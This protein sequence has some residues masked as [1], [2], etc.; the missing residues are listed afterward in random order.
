[1]KKAIFLMVLA[2]FSVSSFAQDMKNRYLFIKGTAE[3][4]GHYEFFIVN[5]TREAKSNGYVVTETES[6]AAHT[7]N[8]VVT[9]NTGAPSDEN[10]Y[11]VKISLLSNTDSLEIISFDF[12][13]TDLN[14]VYKYTRNLFLDATLYIPLFNESEFILAEQLRNQWK[15]KWIY[16]RAS[17][18][19]PITFYELQ[20]TGLI[21][22]SALHN[23][24]DPNI[25]DPQDHKIMA[26][27]GFTVGFE[28]QLFNCFS[29]ELNYQVSWGDT[30]NNYFINLAA[31]AEIKVPIKFQ[32]IVLVPYGAFAFPLSISDI[33][34]E[35]PLFALGPGVQVYAR[36]GKNGAF[37]ID[38][39][40]LF[41]FTEAVMRN[42][43]LEYGP[44]FAIEPAVIHYKRSVIGI[45]IGYKL[46]FFN[47]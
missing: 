19:Y 21:G 22:G 4:K 43:W 6:E 35:F 10:Q 45:G 17:F 42:P 47:R 33:F 26:M 30:R 8:F 28:F 38:V 40:C 9:P 14:E 27:P 3:G 15:N 18:D 20:G 25:N 5:F 7:L 39:K 16:L 34:T 41:S 37:F 32:N 23:S 31:G 46:G 2:F 29:V 44:Q 1:M 11:V 13:F 12:F 24:S 36:G